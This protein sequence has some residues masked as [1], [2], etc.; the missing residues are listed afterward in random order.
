MEV[1]LENLGNGGVIEKFDYEMKSVIAN[2]LDPNTPQDAKREIN[3]KV[4]LKP[5][6][7]ER[8]VCSMTI[9]VSS[10]LAP[11]TPISSTL[12]VGITGHG[13]IAAKEYLPVQQ[14]LFPGTVQEETQEGKK[15]FPFA[16]A[17]A[18]H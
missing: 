12:A 6:K 8:G 2:I 1:S 14:D 7:A 13:E 10:K 18:G 5:S 9:E 3:L 4:I 11:T 17:G 15:I 16:V